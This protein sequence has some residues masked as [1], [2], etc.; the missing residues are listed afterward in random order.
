MDNGIKPAHYENS[1]KAITKFVIGEYDKLVSEEPASEIYSDM[2]IN[3]FSNKSNKILFLGYNS[4]DTSLIKILEGRGYE[5]IHSDNAICFESYHLAISFGYRHI[6]S[7]ETIRSLGCPII[8]LHMSFLPYN[9]GAHP[10]FWAFYDENK[11]GVAIHELNEGIDTG[12][13]MFR[14]KVAIDDRKS[15]FLEA[16]QRLKLEIEKMFIENIDEILGLRWQAVEQSEKGTI[17]KKSELP[18]G[19]L[20]WDTIIYEEIRRLKLSEDFTIA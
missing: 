9:K 12:P 11:C 6:L 16:H 2:K 7:I 15:T 5:V 1:A 20:G 17:H 18:G 4:N 10:I 14:K 8:N 19:F 13:I 3:V